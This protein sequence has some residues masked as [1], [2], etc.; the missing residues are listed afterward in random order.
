MAPEDAQNLQ[1]DWHR[2]VPKSISPKYMAEALCG[3]LEIDEFNNLVRE[4]RSEIFKDALNKDAVR[5]LLDLPKLEQIVDGPGNAIS[6][7]DIYTNAHMIRL[8]DIHHRSGKTPSAVAADNIAKGATLRFRNIEQYDP[9]LIEFAKYVSA[10]YAATTEINVYLTPPGHAGFPPHFDNKDVFIVQVAGSKLWSLYPSYT[11]RVPLPD[12]ETPWDPDT[13]QP[14]GKGLQHQL[15]AGDVLY[16]PRG[17]MH[18]ALCTQE[19]SLHLTISLKSI[20]IADL[21]LK[22]IKR[23]ARTDLALRQRAPWSLD[24]SAED[25]ARL[26]QVLHSQL[27]SIADQLE[28]ALSLDTGRTQATYVDGRDDQT[29]LQTTITALKEMQTRKL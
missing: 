24:D 13:Y 26:A 20:S 10:A 28:P 29:V 14:I 4:Q 2:P 1:S 16:I 19:E 23:I 15:K 18:S 3:A 17:E 7:A 25:H 22:E 5:V 11:N 8:V 9:L 6:Q 27:I 12:P 21:L